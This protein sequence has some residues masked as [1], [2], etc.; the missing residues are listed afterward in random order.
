MKEEEEGKRGGLAEG[1]G[2]ACCCLQVKGKQKY[3]PAMGQS[4]ILPGVLPVSFRV[5]R[6][7]RAPAPLRSGRAT[8]KAWECHPL[9]A[10]E[11]VG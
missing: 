4:G 11:Q 1:G 6:L 3:H 9:P 7:C 2:K 5:C 8:Y 10:A